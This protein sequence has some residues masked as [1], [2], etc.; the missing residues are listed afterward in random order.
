[1]GNLTIISDKKSWEEACGRLAPPSTL[2]DYAMVHAGT[3]LFPDDE[4]LAEAA[5]YE[6]NGEI[7][8]HPYIKRPCPYQSDMFDICS[9]YEFGGFW[10]S[11]EDDDTC[12]ALFKGFEAAFSQH[13]LEAN[14]VSEFVRI[15]PFCNIGG[16][17]WRGYEIGQAGQHIIIPTKSGEEAIWKEFNGSRRT[18]IRKG[19]KKGLRIECSEDIDTF[20][21][22]YYKRL[23]ALNSYRFYYFP[24]AYLKQLE[25]KKIICVYDDQDELCG[26]QVWIEDHGVWFYFLSADIYEKRQCNPS[27]FAIYEMIK[28]ACEQK[29]DYIHLGGGAES[30]YY[31]KSLFS[32]HHIDYFQAKQIF[33]QTAYDDLVAQHKEANGE[34]ENKGY[35]PLY[36]LDTSDPHKLPNKRRYTATQTLS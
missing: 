34:L 19:Q 18:E 21:D 9:A 2:A 33:N 5:L 10:F 1:M 11:S 27:A 4:A 7:L 13:A 20:I 17:N 31:F 24:A 30:L 25:N 32:P 28:R 12:N 3:L 16:I 6:E 15:N 8:F 23:D 29:V 35:F 14:I 26:S 36:R 22:I